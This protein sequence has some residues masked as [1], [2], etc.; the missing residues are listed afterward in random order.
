MNSRALHIYIDRMVVEGLP[1]MGQRRFVRALETQLTQMANDGLPNVFTGGA[2]RIPTLDAG[3]MRAGATPEQA[4]SQVTAA[5]R[6]AIAR[7]G[8]N[9]NG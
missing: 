6:S 9:H 5:L 3:R 4:A 7:K 8:T 2:R 1:L